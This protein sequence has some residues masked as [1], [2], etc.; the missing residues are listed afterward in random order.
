M[1]KRPL[2]EQELELTNKG[3]VR[4]EKENEELQEQV[5]FNQ[6]TIDFQKAQTKYQNATRPYL[7]KQKETEDKKVMGALNEQI[8]SNENTKE[9]LRN[10]IKNGVT[11]KS[12]TEVK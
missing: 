8:K 5:N 9:N 1:T 12:I 11:I 6:L 10:Q 4:L 2:D 3:I 7:M